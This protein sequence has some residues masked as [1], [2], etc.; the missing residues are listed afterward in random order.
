MCASCGSFGQQQKWAS[1]NLAGPETSLP[2]CLGWSQGLEVNLV[3]QAGPA[4][5][6]NT[7]FSLYL[8]PRQSLSTSMRTPNGISLILVFRFLEGS[9]EIWK[10]ELPCLSTID[11]F[12]F[13]L[14]DFYIK[15]KNK[16]TL[17]GWPELITLEPVPPCATGEGL[18][19]IWAASLCP[20][21]M[22]L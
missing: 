8:P 1:P 5:M 2:P 15:T 11:L 10:E 12:W 20:R 4:L 22:H 7:C 18:I 17:Q 6:K 21:N 19:S 14:T 3:S 9:K 16:G 13:R